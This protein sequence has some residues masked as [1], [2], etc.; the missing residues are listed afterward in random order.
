MSTAWLQQLLTNLNSATVLKGIRNLFAGGANSSV[1]AD[2]VCCM[3]NKISESLDP[4]IPP[5]ASCALLDFPNYANVGDSAIWLGQSEYLRKRGA[6]VIFACDQES[7]SRDELAAQLNDDSLILLQG[8]GNLG[9]LWPWHQKLRERVIEDFPK[10]KIIIFPQSIYFQADDSLEEAKRIFESH[11]DLTLMVREEQSLRVAEKNFQVPTIQCPDMAFF[12]EMPALR[13]RP[14]AAVSCLF[15]TDREAKEDCRPNANESILVDD[16]VV[17]DVLSESPTEIKTEAQNSPESIL[18][19]C[20][21]AALQRLNR[22]CRLL[23][24]GRVVV[25][26]RLHGHII[27]I[28][29]G[30]PNLV[31]DNSYGKVRAVFDTWTKDSGISYWEENREEAVAHALILAGKGKL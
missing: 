19:A 17:D 2:F 21:R 31:I 27:S 1:H 22:G 18:Q 23:A 4:L 12:L 26:D 13:S 9:D 8:G 16:W 15:R 24:Q 7:Y 25:T 20:D 3:R 14:Q 11:P 29:M 28:L 5:G 10:H 6:K 30:I